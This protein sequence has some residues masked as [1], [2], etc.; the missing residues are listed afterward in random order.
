[1]KTIALIDT[2]QGG[3][4]L[5]YLRLFAKT[6]LELGYEVMSFCPHP[7]ELSEWIARNCPEQ[8]RQFHAFA[9]QEP[10]P[11]RLPVVGKLPQPFTV[12]ARWQYAAATIQSA[13]SEIGSSPDLVFFNWM[14]SYLSHY[15]T[16]QIIDRV[17]PYNWS[18]LYFQPRLQFEQKTSHN[19]HGFLNHQAVLNSSCCR[20]VAVLDKG[21][22]RKLQHKV[23]NTVLTFPDLTDE[24]PPDFSF[25]VV[26]Q[27]R[28]KAASRNIVGLI[29]SLNKR[30]GLLTLL[31]A[32]QK[33][34]QENCFFVFAGQLSEYGLLPEELAK[35][36]AIVEQTPPNCFFY[37]ERIPDEP[38]FNALI[39]EC[40]ILFAA[41]EDFP[42]SSNI[43]TKAAIFRK[44][45]IA[46]ENF[47][48]GERVKEFNLGLTI[49]EG[50]VSKC[51][52][53][54][55]EL[56]NNSSSSNSPLA[57]NFEGYER[58]NS[59]ERLRIMFSELTELSRAPKKAI[60]V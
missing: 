41:Y 5:T 32:A 57:P 24:S 58:L 53:A 30:K 34:Q 52:E 12:L 39:A 4:H 1:M 3:H 35:I 13:S 14:D 10:K 43:L 23:R 49:P 21:I 9:A 28:E 31:E 47:C 36:R 60:K 22:A 48:I 17:F 8:T 18:G 42:Y 27:I 15:L 37:L 33:M 7:P 56:T 20:A 55:H 25:P 40:D 44:R 46:S 59:L 6:L 45:L 51:I 26:Q 54:L 16:P 19:H 2:N 11:R 29:G 38:Q 50:D